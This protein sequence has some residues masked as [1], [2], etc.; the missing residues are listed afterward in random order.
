MNIKRASETQDEY[1]ALRFA[2]LKNVSGANARTDVAMMVRYGWKDIGQTAFIWESSNASG[3][4][5]KNYTAGTVGNTQHTSHHTKI[6]ATLE[7]ST[8]CAYLSGTID[9]YN[10]L[11]VQYTNEYADEII[12]A[13]IKT[14]ED[15]S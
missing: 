13:V 11:T 1:D 10:D 3:N 14:Y 4:T 7:T 6:T 8:R 15:V 12:R 9:D 2:F 5:F